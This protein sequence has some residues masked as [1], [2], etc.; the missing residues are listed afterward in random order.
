[1]FCLIH[2]LKHNFKKLENTNKI[3]ILRDHIEFFIYIML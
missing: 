1:M 3:E 2:I